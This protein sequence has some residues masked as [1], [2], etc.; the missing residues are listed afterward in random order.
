MFSTDVSCTMVTPENTIVELAYVF[1]ENN[2]DF[3]VANPE[4]YEMTIEAYLATQIS[5]T[6]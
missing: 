4:T 3:E 5:H 1:T 6:T 2:M